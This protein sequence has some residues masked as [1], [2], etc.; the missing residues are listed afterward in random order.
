MKLKCQRS[1]LSVIKSTESVNPCSTHT[2]RTT[3]PF[4]VCPNSYL[5][6]RVL[7]YDGQYCIQTWSGE[8]CRL[9][10]CRTAPFPLY[11]YTK[12]ESQQKPKSC[13][14]ARLAKFIVARDSSEQDREPPYTPPSRHCLTLYR[15][16]IISGRL[17][18]ISSLLM[19][20]KASRFK[21]EELIFFES[22]TFFFP[23]STEMSLSFS[24]NFSPLTGK[25]VFWL[26]ES[27]TEHA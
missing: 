13:S 23:N 19:I 24:R 3:V 27:W 6:V 9:W 2:A 15:Y 12:A 4:S 20:P 10:R 22:F 8:L 5:K 26:T 1:H 7:Y 11:R 21:E 17:S 16:Q 25:K 14:L 18:S